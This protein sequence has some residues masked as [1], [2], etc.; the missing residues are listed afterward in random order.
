MPSGAGSKG[1]IRGANLKTRF[2]SVAW[3][4][5]GC[6]RMSGKPQNSDKLPS[7]LRSTKER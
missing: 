6:L 2:S 5:A 4:S 7:K 3:A 1:G